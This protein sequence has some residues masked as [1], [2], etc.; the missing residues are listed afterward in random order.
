MS[1]RIITLNVSEQ[2][3][4]RA[5]EIAART[6]QPVEAVLQSWLESA[7][8]VPPL[9]PDDEAELQA[10]QALSDDALW[11]IA[12]EQMPR[13]EQERLSLL[14][15]LN[16]RGAATDE[17]ITALDR[18]LERGDRL[19]LRKAEAAAILTRRGYTVRSENL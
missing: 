5:Q 9:S 3:Y 18:L 19:M 12:G 1:D 7:V 13:P 11:T 16:E 6:A 17:E 10:I 8:N 2:A 15:K 4:T 14:L